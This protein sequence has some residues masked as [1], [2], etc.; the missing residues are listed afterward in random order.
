MAREVLYRKIANT[1]EGQ[2][3]S[4][5][6]KIGDKLPS[7]RTVQKIYEVSLNT[8]KQAF[9][10]LESK[11]LIESRPKSGYYVSRSFSR[12]LAVPSVS[13]PKL[14]E[15]AYQPEDL[16]SR[17]FDTLSDSSI[18]KFSLG[19]ADNS[20]VPIAKLNKSMLKVL[21]SMSDSG[22]AYEPVQGSVN[23][24]RNISKWSFVWGG[25]L[26]EDDIVTTSG[27]LNSIFNCLLAVT[28]PGD[29]IA[30][31]SPIYFGILQMIQSLGLKIIELPTNPITGIEIE[32]LKKV[33]PKIKVCLLVSNFNNPLGSCMPDEHKK[34]VVRMLAAR[35]IPLIED[36]LYGD[37]YFGTS[38]P[39][40]CKLY[41]EEGLVM[42]CGS[43]S[44]TLAPGYRVGWVAPGKFKD[45]IIRQKMLQTISN[46]PL[47]AEAI[48]DFLEHGRY[49]HH[50]RTLRS[51]LYSNCL[52]YQRAVEDYFPE[53]TKISKPQGGFVLWLELDQG[54][55]TAALYE[56]AIKHKIS[57]APGRMFTQHNQFNNCMRLNF[58]LKWD[59]QLDFD[60]KKLGQIVKNSL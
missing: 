47:Q 12:R 7:I 6:L 57:F 21:R 5:T 60:L 23:L 40:P 45:K 51:K 19:V 15:K 49:D 33:L 26:V 44:K 38:R 27:A 29:C 43:F 56:T 59:K 36:D 50:L 31:E 58:G 55:D 2:I 22:T 30:I 32:A 9:L 4:E 16:I 52:Q 1:I 10:E 3:A 25:Q 18:T 34:E 13:T 48:A 39:A 8:V 35:H 11:S 37:L 53:C 20:M 14:S 41:D 42:W 17:V 54:I 24:R 46:P 28:Q